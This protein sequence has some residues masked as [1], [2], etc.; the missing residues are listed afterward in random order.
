MIKKVAWELNKIHT[1]T[2]Q[3]GVL[4]KPDQRTKFLLSLIECLSK[5]KNKLEMLGG[6][7]KPHKD[8]GLE[9]QGR[10]ILCRKPRPAI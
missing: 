2:T 1:T 4:K 8:E 9:S 6:E 5:G 3:Q 10:T 7:V